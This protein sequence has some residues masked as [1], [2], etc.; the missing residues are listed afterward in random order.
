MSVASPEVMEKWLCIFAVLSIWIIWWHSK[1]LHTCDPK[2]WCIECWPVICAVLPPFIVRF[3]LHNS[4]CHVAQLHVYRPWGKFSKFQIAQLWRRHSYD[5]S[6]YVCGMHAC[7][8][9][10]RF[11]HMFFWFACGKV[12]PTRK[13]NKTRSVFWRTMPLDMAG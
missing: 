5:H 6:L 12:K 4:T 10:H 8:M 2:L 1:R 13:T 11:W 7:V 3:K 9:S